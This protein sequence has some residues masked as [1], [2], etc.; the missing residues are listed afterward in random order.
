MPPIPTVAP[1]ISPW[2][3]YKPNGVLDISF[4][5]GTGTVLTPFAYGNAAAN[6]VSVYSNG[7]I[8]VAG[9]APDASSGNSDFALVRY[10]STG[11]LDVAFGGG[12]GTVLTPFTYG[13]AVA[14]GIVVVN[15]SQD[16][17]VAGY[18]PDPTNGGNDFAV[19]RYRSS[20]ELDTTFAG[21][22]VMTAFGGDA[23]ANGL[24]LDGSGN[25]L[26]AGYA[27]DPTSGNNDFAVARYL[28][29][30]TTPG[31]LDTTFGGGGTG[32]VL[33]PM[34]S[35][36]AQANGLAVQ[37]NGNIAAAGYAADLI[38]GTNDFAVAVYSPAG[39]LN[40]GFGT[41]GTT[42]TSIGNGVSEGEWR[43]PGCQWQYRGRWI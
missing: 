25:V 7:Y 6:G 29:Q 12:S 31:A 42:L 1:P 26:V 37:S 5:G 24:A 17:V 23:E 36:N 19:A 8:V 9:Y 39:L 33:T 35:S 27:P 4:G 21:G 11:T 41:G 40:A 20:G 10:R 18:A 14:T 38:T 16:I 22:T 13:D 32:W 3:R 2:P 30:G 28:G 15:S 34:G 43:G